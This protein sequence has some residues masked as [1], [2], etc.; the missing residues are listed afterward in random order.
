MLNLLVAARQRRLLRR[1]RSRVCMGRLKRGWAGLRC[2]GM[3]LRTAVRCGVYDSSCVKRR[4]N[5]CGASMATVLTTSVWHCSG[6]GRL[7][8]ESLFGDHL[9]RAK[10]TASLTTS[11]QQRRAALSGRSTGNCSSRIKQPCTGQCKAMTGLRG[12]SCMQ[13]GHAHDHT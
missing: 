2:R 11:L 6:A 12:H 3:R 7:L 9:H 4:V 1:A 5:R 10:L 8:C 13:S